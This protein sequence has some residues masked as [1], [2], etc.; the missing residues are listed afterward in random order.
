MMTTRCLGALLCAAMLTACTFEDGQP[1]GRAQVQL[2]TSS[3]FTQRAVSPNRLRVGNGF[4]LE[5]QQFTWHVEA[6]ELALAPP[7]T[8]SIDFDPSA[9]PAGYSLCHNGHCHADD[10]RLVDY[11]DI[12]LELHSGMGA[13]ALAF[14]QQLDGQQALFTTPATLAG[15]PERCT[16]RCELERGVLTLA[17]VNIKEVTLTGIAHDVR[18][19]RLPVEGHPVSITLT[20]PISFSALLDDAQ[21]GPGEPVERVLRARLMIGASVFDDIAWGDPVLAPQRFRANLLEHTDFTVNSTP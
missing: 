3:D 14:V 5:V 4:E 1:W 17:S 13:S 16:N 12:A 21:I 19:E 20:E 18:D 11:E 9:P 8:A 7:S 10:G 2:R 6:I 15:D